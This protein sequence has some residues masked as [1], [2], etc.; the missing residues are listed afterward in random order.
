MSPA[1][2]RPRTLLVRNADVLVTMDG[3]RRE[4]PGG[5]LFA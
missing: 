4:I 1:G 2:P 3:K 5:G